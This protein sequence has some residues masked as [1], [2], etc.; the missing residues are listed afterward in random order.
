[1]RRKGMTMIEILIAVFILALLI[2]VSAKT[3]TNFFSSSLLDQVVQGSIS[4]LE[5][6]REDS[7][8]GK[9]GFFYGVHFATTSITIFSGSAYSLG[10]N[11]NIVA[12][13]P[14][15]VQV[16]STTL[17]GGGANVIFSPI[18][19]ETNNAGV[20]IFLNSRS[21]A[22]SAVRIYA[23]GISKKE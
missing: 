4:S 19:G 2:T 13:L 8:G 15:G 1:M 10:A 11:G 21:N 17:D 14:S 23:T 16:A 18:S 20:V 22:T 6:A 12:N 7:I 9:N 3:F 5:K